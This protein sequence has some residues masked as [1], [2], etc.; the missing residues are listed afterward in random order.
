MPVSPSI[1]AGE[2]CSIQIVIRTRVM[3]QKY[4]EIA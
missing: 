3:L 2:S 1:E 4:S